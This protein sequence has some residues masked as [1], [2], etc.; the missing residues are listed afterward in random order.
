[1]HRNEVLLVGRLS[2]EP[3]HKELPS[4]AMLTQWRLA[5]RRPEDHPGPQRADAIECS[6]FH[7]DVRGMLDGWRLDDVVEVEGALRRR[8]WRG[9]S[10]Y[11]IEV[12]TARQ[13]E[14]AGSR[15]PARRNGRSPRVTRP[16]HAAPDAVAPAGPGPAGAGPAGV[17]SERAGDGD[18]LG[19]AAA[20]DDRPAAAGPETAGATTLKRPKRW[21]G[22]RPW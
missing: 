20:R 1:M 16:D 9:G 11:E 18:E 2:M 19:V 12:R 21:R 22:R 4:G 17:C 10:R 5:V 3:V 7:D 15:V 14:Q 6:T 13:V 8:W